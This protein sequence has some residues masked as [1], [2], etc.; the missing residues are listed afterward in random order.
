MVAVRN[1][2]LQ[3]NRHA[4]PVLAVRQDS[5]ESGEVQVAHQPHPVGEVVLAVETRDFGDGLG[6]AVLHVVVQPDDGSQ[7]RRQDVTGGVDWAVSDGDPREGISLLR[8]RVVELA[9]P[10]ENL[11]GRLSPRAPPSTAAGSL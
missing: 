6:V 11:V 9:I 4:H 7:C 3:A 1:P 2:H 10:T 5:H 8:V